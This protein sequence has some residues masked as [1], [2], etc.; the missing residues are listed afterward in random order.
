MPHGSDHRLMFLTVRFWWRMIAINAAA[1]LLAVVAFTNVSWNTPWRRVG[2]VFAVSFV[3]SLCITPLCFVAM[4]SLSPVV[5]RRV[6]FPLNW[7]I[8]IATLV[9]I[10]VGG[11]LLGTA[12]L[13][14]AGHVP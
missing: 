8:L 4:A 13:V 12:I 10:A 1:S 3:L 5:T 6:P 9:V 14:L 11:T 7:A 2:E